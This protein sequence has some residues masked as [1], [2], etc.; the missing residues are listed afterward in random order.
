MPSLMKW[1]CERS[2]RKHIDSF[3]GRGVRGGFLRGATT[4]SIM[5]GKNM[6]SQNPLLE[7]AFLRSY[8]RLREY[9]VNNDFEIIL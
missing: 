4:P 1:K 2:F 7:E 9:L 6:S 3:A 8:E 5:R